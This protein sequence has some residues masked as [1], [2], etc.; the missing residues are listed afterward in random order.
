MSLSQGFATISTLRA[1][2]AVSYPLVD[3]KIVKLGITLELEGSLLKLLS[4]YYKQV[5]TVPS[6]FL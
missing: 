2:F 6:N 5:Y 4:Y 1:N 3:W